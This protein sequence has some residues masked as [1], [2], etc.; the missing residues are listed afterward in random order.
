MIS[1]DLRFPRGILD[2]L[3]VGSGRRP[4]SEVF[5]GMGYVRK[6]LEPRLKVELH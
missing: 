6:E 3:E 1:K 4:K 2:V 5:Q